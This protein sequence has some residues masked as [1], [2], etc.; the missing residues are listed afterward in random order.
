MEFAFE[1]LKAAVCSEI[2]NFITGTFDGPLPCI[3]QSFVALT[4][5][6]R[7]G[8]QAEYHGAFRAA[9]SL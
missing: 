2:L 6:D 3:M 5:N 8:R 4:L 1:F 9:A 7:Y